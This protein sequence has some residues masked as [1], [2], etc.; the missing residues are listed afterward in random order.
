MIPEILIIV[1]M[2]AVFGLWIH[3]LIHVA[4]SEAKNKTLWIVLLALLGAI[5]LPFYWVI[6]PYKKIAK[7]EE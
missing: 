6:K 4:K 3:A 7:K 2:L 1:V 5:V